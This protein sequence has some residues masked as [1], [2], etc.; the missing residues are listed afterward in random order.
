MWCVSLSLIWLIS[1]LQ[2]DRSEIWHTSVME[3]K[4]TTFT[5]SNNNIDDGYFDEDINKFVH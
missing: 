2:R 1:E 3:K 5:A 4:L